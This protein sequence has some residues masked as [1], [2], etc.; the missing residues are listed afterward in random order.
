MDKIVGH[1]AFLAGI[2]IA[3]IA[4]IG[5]AALDQSIVAILLVVLGIVVGIMNITT[6]EEVS[7]IVACAGLMLAA[8]VDLSNL[9]VLA[10]ILKAM[11][12]NILLFVAPA[13]IA[14]ALKLV[15]RLAQD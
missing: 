11:L 5:V 13:S 1:Y 14:V 6:E 12:G 9:P 3:I 7:F 8:N 2:V 4:G 15:Y 10:D